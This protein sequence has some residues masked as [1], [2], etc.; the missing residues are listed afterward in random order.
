L[1]AISVSG[2]LSRFDR[3]L[4]AKLKLLLREIAGTLTDRLGGDSALFGSGR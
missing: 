4:I 3:R 2:P 1:G